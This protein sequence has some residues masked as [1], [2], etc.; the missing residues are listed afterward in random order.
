MYEE[1]YRPFVVT[2]LVGNILW[3]VSRGFIHAYIISPDWESLGS[4]AIERLAGF[5]PLVALV[6]TGLSFGLAIEVAKFLGAVM[7]SEGAV[8]FLPIVAGAGIGALQG[9]FVSTEIWGFADSVAYRSEVTRI[10]SGAA[11]GFILTVPAI[12]IGIGIRRRG[13]PW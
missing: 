13:T 3:T 7:R 6:S 2:T 12:M 10:L 9:A 5:R 11:C 4:T 1:M 8:M